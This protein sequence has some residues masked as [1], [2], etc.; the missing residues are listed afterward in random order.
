MLGTG[1]ESP[2]FNTCVAEICA[3]MRTGTAYNVA[4][5]KMSRGG[6][7][8]LLP[9]EGDATA[10]NSSEK[11]RDVEWNRLG[12]NQLT[13]DKEWKLSPHNSSPITD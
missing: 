12:D 7:G 8:T 11:R 4:A 1:S 2:T 3:S 10:E 9:E 6:F 13:T 5:L